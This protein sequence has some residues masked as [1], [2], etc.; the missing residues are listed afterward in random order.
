MSPSRRHTRITT[1]LGDLL[2]VAS[3][4]AVVGAYFDGQKYQPETAWFG[5]DVTGTGDDVLTE[6]SR[7]LSEYFS[8]NR[9]TFDLPLAP[10]GT[11]F[12]QR[13]W[14]QLLLI[15]PGST[16]TYGAIAAAL[17]DD[18]ELTPGLAQGVG[19]AVGHNPVSVVVPCHRV[20]GSDGS[21][22]GFAGGLER[23]RWL[24]AHEESDEQRATRLF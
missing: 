20:V 13:V 2:L 1:P 9:L 22:T 18:G 19:Q 12:Q 11:T 21:L 7:Q 16:S 6:G 10:V 14:Q 24:L 5:D 8:G 4:D 17:S 23:K 3:A 15:E